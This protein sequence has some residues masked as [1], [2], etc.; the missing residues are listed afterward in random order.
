MKHFLVA[1]CLFVFAM[2]TVAEEKSEK[3]P[4]KAEAKTTVIV[5]SIADKDS[6]ESL[7]GVEV[8]IKGTDLKT[9]TDFDG[10]FA[11]ENVNPGDYELV[12]SYISYEKKTQS[13]SVSPAN[14]EVSIKLELSN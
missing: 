13:L 4:A 1:A 9:Y 12:S 7:V 5:G 8:K 2:V 6:G 3:A 14:N 11:F 10:K